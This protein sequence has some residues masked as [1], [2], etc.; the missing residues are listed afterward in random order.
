MDQIFTKNIPNKLDFDFKHGDHTFDYEYSQ[1]NLKK[2]RVLRDVS[3]DVYVDVM[4]SDKR[5]K[6][7]ERATDGQLENDKRERNRLNF[8]TYVYNA[9]RFKLDFEL[10]EQ[11]LA[12]NITLQKDE[13]VHL[14]FKGGSMMYY[15][16]EKL[17]SYLKEGTVED[18]RKSFDDKFKISDFDFTI[19]ITVKDPKVFYQVK[20]I[21]NKIV[22]NGLLDIRKFFEDYIVMV[23]LQ[24]IQATNFNNKEIETSLLG[25]GSTIEPVV[26]AK[27]LPIKDT[28][29]TKMS[30]TQIEECIH[31]L[32]Q[33]IRLEEVQKSAD[34]KQNLSKSF[35]EHQALLITNT[36]NTFF[37]QLEAVIDWIASFNLLNYQEVVQSTEY[38]F[39]KLLQIHRLLVIV[40]GNR[41]LFP[42]SIFPIKMN[43]SQND[44]L[45]FGPFFDIVMVIKVHLHTVI[46]FIMNTF[47]IAA[48]RNIV[49]DKFYVSTV[50]GKDVNTL[51]LI[52]QGIT[53]KLKERDITFVKTPY[54]DFLAFQDRTNDMSN[55]D[56]FLV[57]TVP[58][59][60][61]YDDS[62]SE[63]P[64]GDFYIQPDLL[65]NNMMITDSTKNSYH[66]IYQN[67]V[68]KKNRNM[69]SSIVDFDLLRIKLNFELNVE[70]A[71][72][73]S[74]GTVSS[75]KTFKIPS[76][77]IDISICGY[78][79]SSLASFRNHPEH[80]MHIYEIDYTTEDGTPY[81]LECV[82]YSIDF[83]MHD[84][85]YVLYSQNIFTPWID[86]KYEKRLY[87]LTGIELLYRILSGTLKE[88]LASMMFSY[89]LVNYCRTYSECSNFEA[90]EHAQVDDVMRVLSGLETNI[91]T[92]YG[93]YNF[94]K[95]THVA[96]SILIEPIR[97]FDQDIN[98]TMPFSDE[99]IGSVV[100]YACLL[101]YEKNNRGNEAISTVALDIINKYRSDFLYYNLRQ[102]HY[103]EMMTQASL[104]LKSIH[105]IFVEMFNFGKSQLD[106]ATL[107]NKTNTVYGGKKKPIRSKGRKAQHSMSFF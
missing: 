4:F 3:T 26:L 27:T 53:S 60:N 31:S 54:D 6:N 69:N 47:N 41:H 95:V 35:F 37:V 30:C 10:P 5:I 42:A 63:A 16:Y 76:E 7:T 89:I 98:S 36:R 11:L 12:H 87:R 51:E 56:N 40:Q 38:H 28:I 15:L 55:E 14:L 20:L 84:L 74:S 65:S 83:T 81:S 61:I 91:V 25:L 104:Y 100:F 2:E 85:T 94:Q 22:F 19:Y 66:Y 106:E 59:D 29:T 39:G 82:G 8:L 23:N 46:T 107:L 1:H 73:N 105:N 90:D 99:I 50:N 64:R 21:V 70:V 52:R 67:S 72:P 48:Q 80:A 86:G 13:K 45:Q 33:L 88:Y 49:R 44:D 77:F 101:R 78:D 43:N 71:D 68:I 79:D 58:K 103:I 57:Y 93:R 97:F 102:E 34:E 32:Q 92:Y 17:I 75:M 24:A 96:P 18:F 9:L 62:V